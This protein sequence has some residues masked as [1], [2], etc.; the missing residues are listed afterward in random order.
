MNCKQRVLAFIDRR[1]SG[2]RNNQNHPAES[3]QTQIIGILSD[4]IK[5]A[6]TV[7]KKSPIPRA[8]GNRINC[9][10]IPHP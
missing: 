6:F 2:R 5:S 8:F 3:L 4:A 7:C 1:P 9:A 10:A